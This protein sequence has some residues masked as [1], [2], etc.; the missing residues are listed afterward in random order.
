M[1]PAQVRGLF[2]VFAERQKRDAADMDKLAWLNGNYAGT[3]FHAPKRYPNKPRNAEKIMGP[4]PQKNM[5]DEQMKSAMMT[6]AKRWN[7]C[8]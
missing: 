8:Q 2:Q 3:A 6:F 7:K 5:T 4:A 1:T